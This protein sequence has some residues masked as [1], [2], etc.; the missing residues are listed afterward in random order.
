MR[1]W[2]L[3]VAP[4]TVVFYF[5]TFPEQLGPTIDWVKSTMSLVLASL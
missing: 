2:L 3:V 5:L 1:E 4:L